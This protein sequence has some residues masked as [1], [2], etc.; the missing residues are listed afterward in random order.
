MTVSCT[1]RRARRRGRDGANS[2][3]V[4]VRADQH[5]HH[6]GRGDRAWCPFSLLDDLSG[7]SEQ[8]RGLL[9][10]PAEAKS[11]SCNTVVPPA[12][13]LSSTET[14]SV[15][16]PP[17][18][19]GGAWSVGE[20]KKTYAVVNSRRLSTADLQTAG[21][22]AALNVVSTQDVTAPTLTA[23]SFRADQ[24]RHHHRRGD[25]V[26]CPFRCWTI[27]PVTRAASLSSRVPSGGQSRSCNT[28]VPPAGTL[29]STETCSVVFPP[30]GEEGAWSVGEG[31]PV[32]RG[33]EHPEAFHRRPA[34]GR[35]PRCSERCQHAGRD[36]ANSY[37]VLVRA[38]QH[39]HHHPERR[40][41]RCP[42]RCWTISPVTR[43]AS[44]PFRVPAE[45]SLV[46]ATLYFRP[47]ALCR[48]S[49]RAASSSRRSAREGPGASARSSCPTRWGTP[50]GFPPPTCRQRAFRRGSV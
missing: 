1:R 5:R 29:S 41:F 13:T 50:G 7:N 18:G 37:G 28:V 33:G 42:F 26:R 12:G 39:R 38:D 35:L 3:G 48:P 9:E 2:Y 45:A 6:H 30:F 32:R 10:S 17:F 25:R 24:H 49:R 22:L 46:L 34:D 31:H 36:G 11:R 21:F 4:L 27:S 40:P 47:L 15:V 14:C 8:R 44:W 16:F 20:V 23:F 19:E 43:A